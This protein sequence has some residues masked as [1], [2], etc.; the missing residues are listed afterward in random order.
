MAYDGCRMKPWVKGLLG[1]LAA[2]LGLVLLFLGWIAWMFLHPLPSENGMR[3]L[4]EK[5]H[6]TLDTL[7]SIVLRDTALVTV[8][9]HPGASFA[10]Y[11][12][13]PPGF[14]NLLT[15]VEVRATGR[16]RYRDLLKE[17]GLRALRRRDS[18]VT[19]RV[20]SNI[21]QT[22][23]FLYSRREISATRSSFAATSRGEVTYLRLAPHWYAI[24]GPGD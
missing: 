4:F 16:L 5:H 7:A 9:G 12:Q 8:I 24:G 10:V 1:P 3:D 22:R 13:G 6:A 14:D 18:T 19:F 23:D 11:V 20:A 2:G 21:E 15:D 17:S